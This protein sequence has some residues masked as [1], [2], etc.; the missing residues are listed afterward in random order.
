MN[1]F[2]REEY[3]LQ[4]E[5]GEII[6]IAYEI[7]KHLGAGF[8]EVV[9]KDAFEYEFIKGNIFFEREKKYTIVYKDVILPHHFFADF[10]VFE[11]IILEIKARE[12]GIIEEDYAQVINYLKA[13]GCKVGLV[14]N[15]SKTK[16][17]I[18]RIIY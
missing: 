4:K 8:L 3:P 10:I 12:G 9:Y 1:S 6:K 17:Q 2:N 5:T 16:V 14:I 7:N 18:K 11:D 15:F 13:S